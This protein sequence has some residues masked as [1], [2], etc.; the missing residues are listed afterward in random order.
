MAASR[1][2]AEV[3]LWESEWVSGLHAA[4]FCVRI[5]VHVPIEHLQQSIRLL[6]LSSG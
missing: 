3:G 5:N 6:F 4:F 2:E 1:E